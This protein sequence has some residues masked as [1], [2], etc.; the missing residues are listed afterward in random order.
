MTNIV[1]KLKLKEE[2]C[3]DAQYGWQPGMNEEEAWRA[4][5]GDW[6]ADPTRV[7]ECENA[8]VVDPNSKIVCV[9]SISGVKRAE[10]APRI[11]ILGKVLSGNPWVGRTMRVNDSRNPIAYIKGPMDVFIQ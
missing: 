2:G 5:Q 7:M 8:I 3:Q 4:A 1:L 6:R 9:A 10:E 11:K